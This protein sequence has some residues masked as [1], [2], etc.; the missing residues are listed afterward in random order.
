MRCNR[1]FSR[2]SG[3]RRCSSPYTGC[4]GHCLRLPTWTSTLHA[5]FLVVRSLPR[6]SSPT[7]ATTLPTDKVA[8]RDTPQREGGSRRSCCCCR[9]CCCHKMISDLTPVL[10]SCTCIRTYTHPLR[11]TRRRLRAGPQRS[12]G[13]QHISLP[14]QHLARILPTIHKHA[15]RRWPRRQHASGADHSQPALFVAARVIHHTRP[16]GAALHHSPVPTI[17]SCSRR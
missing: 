16:P 12:R 13:T 5:S 6:D 2:T 4:Y 8:R 17:E 14:D 10:V 3:C 7:L 1:T 9:C 11:V 15:H